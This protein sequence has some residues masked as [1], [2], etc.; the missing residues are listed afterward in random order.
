M[1]LY[2]RILVPVDGSPASDQ[3]VREAARIARNGGSPAAELVLLHV[4]DDHPALVEWWSGISAD[5]IR[6]RLRDYGLTLLRQAHALATACGVEASQVLHAEPGEAIAEAV[7][8]EQARQGCGL[9][10]FG[11]RR[12]KGRRRLAAGSAASEVARC[13]PVP[14][15][16]VH[17][18]DD[19][20]R[21]AASNH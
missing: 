3:G 17:P 19:G 10:V 9:I 15:L 7:L 5:E 16:V 11:M 18:P 20:P 13:S 2:H 1:S 14:V 21:T 12:P 6:K 4:M 8:S